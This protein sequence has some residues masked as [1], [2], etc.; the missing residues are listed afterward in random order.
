MS[1]AQ[2]TLVAYKVERGGVGVIH[3]DF[4][5]LHNVGTNFLQNYGFRATNEKKRVF[6][7][8]SIKNFLQQMGGGVQ[9]PNWWQLRK[10]VARSAMRCAK[11]VV[12]ETGFVGEEKF[13]LSSDGGG[14][15]IGSQPTKII[16]RGPF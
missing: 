11:L 14:F 10:L 16:A 2:V 1:R 15:E 4:G 8:S 7:S 6:C 5:H 12:P 9:L 13:C 3:F